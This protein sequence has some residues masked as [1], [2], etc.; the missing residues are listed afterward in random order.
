MKQISHKYACGGMLISAALERNGCH[1]KVE[2]SSGY[3][4]R[5]NPVTARAFLFTARTHKTFL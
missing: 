4:T 5:P 3:N 1:V 2:I